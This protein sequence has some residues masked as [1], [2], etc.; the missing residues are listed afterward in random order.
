MRAQKVSSLDFVCALFAISLCIPSSEEQRKPGSA[1]VAEK[2]LQNS[3][4]RSPEKQKIARSKSD[5]L[6]TSTRKYPEP[7]T[8][9]HTH[10]HPTLVAVVEEKGHHSD[11]SRRDEEQEENKCLRRQQRASAI[12]E[13]HCKHGQGE[14]QL[15]SHLRQGWI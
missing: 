12:S 6:N 4:T 8:H 3:G 13:Y 1:R 10:T 11:K 14:A 7:P 2:H 9:T 15:D 5:R